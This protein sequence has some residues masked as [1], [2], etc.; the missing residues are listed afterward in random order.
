MIYS[1][2]IPKSHQE[3]VGETTVTMSRR[4]QG[5]LRKTL[6]E[7]KN[8]VHK[9]MSGMTP[10]KAVVALLMMYSETWKVEKIERLKQEGKFIYERTAAMDQKGVPGGGDVRAN[11]EVLFRKRQRTRFVIMRREKVQGEYRART[12][13]RTGEDE[14]TAM[15]EER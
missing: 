3:N 14:R 15:S 12:W 4:G 2:T 8:A 5:H 9:M 1:I 6:S 7:G 11:G 10:Y 13:W